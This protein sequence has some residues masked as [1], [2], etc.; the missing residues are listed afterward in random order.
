[1]TNKSK[2]IC[3]SVTKK[4]ARIHINKI[5]ADYERFQ[6][7]SRNVINVHV[8]ALYEVLERGLELDPVTVWQDDE[9]ILW[10]VDGHHRLAAYKR[11]LKNVP[12]RK[13]KVA[14]ASKIG[15]V[16]LRGPLDRVRLQTSTENSKNR[17]N[18]TR[19]EKSQA[20][21][22]II[23]ESCTVTLAEVAATGLVS[24]RTAQTMRNVLNWFSEEFGEEAVGNIPQ[25][26]AKARATYSMR[27]NDPEAQR[28][29]EAER[30]AVVRERLRKQVGYPIEKVQPSDVDIVLSVVAEALGD[31]TFETAFQEWQNPYCEDFEDFFEEDGEDYCDDRQLKLPLGLPEYFLGP[32]SDDENEPF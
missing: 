6:P 9:G 13:R 17:L 24:S 29:D 18:L 10:V 23:R 4:S 7:R 1:M 25:E 3:G 16:V 19:E 22:D 21:W 5:N 2:G 32:S 26:W 30:R 14:K 8:G 15:V 12:A 27:N 11:Y 28:D 20:A 31:E